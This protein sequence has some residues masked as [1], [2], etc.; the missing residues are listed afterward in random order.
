[1]PR[2]GVP[3]RAAAAAIEQGEPR[4]RM[5]MQQPDNQKNLLLAILMSVGVLLLWQ[6]LYAGPKLKEEQERQ[7]RI[8][9]EQQAKAPVP[10]APGTVPGVGQP[11][12]PAGSTPAAAPPVAAVGAMTREQALKASPRIQIDTP[13]IAGSISLKGA[14]IDDVRLK[15]HREDARPGSPLVA[16][17]SPSEASD[18]YFAEHGWAGATGS[19]A[20]LPT[21]DTLWRAETS[22]ALAPDKPVVLGWDNG[23]GLSFRRTIS[24]DRDY[25]FR[26]TDE[27][28]N[29]GQSDLAVHPYARLFRY[30]IPKIEGFFI[31]HEGLIGFIGDAR[32]QELTYSDVQKDGGSRNYKDK[33]GGW[34]GFTDKYWATALVPPQDQP[35]TANLALAQKK[36]AATDKEA[37]QADYI[38][39]AVALPRGS[40]TKI[41]NRLFAG[42]KQVGIVN[43]YEAN[44]KI[45]EFNYVID[46]GWF[47]FITK[48]LYY[49]ITWFNQLLGNFGLAILAVTVLVK[50]A[51]FPLA[52]KSYES[53]AKMKKLQPEMER[54]KERY[55]D[56]KPA[57]QKE[58]MTLYQKE[59]INP[60]AGCLPILLQIPVFFALYKVLFVSIDMRH[61]PFFGWIKDLSAADPTSIFNLFGLLPYAVPEFLQVGV[62]P[63][64][65]GATMWLQMQLNPKQ[66]D[67]IQ[68]Q[69]FNWMPVIFTFLLA[70]FPAGLV[71]YWAWNNVLSLMQQYVIMKRQKVDV[72]L[73]DN[74]KAAIAGLGRMFGKPKA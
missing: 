10:G 21:P 8:Q 28:S 33:K 34:L 49:L 70:T 13:S 74:L 66:P 53:M 18:S 15:R 19:Q 29:Q 16:V 6:V 45:L 9:A 22:H 42:A 14:R 58:L 37:F 40:T 43:A 4:Q 65:M 50:V 69:I 46:W 17:L 31:Q 55:K 67:P 64:I 54:L 51:F 56:D 1:M 2:R 48:P 23:D 73:V 61:A 62:W 5:Q 35:Y 7:R 27:V 60:A 20:R 32:L 25:M 52:N 38:M 24:V 72:P 11:P 26:I 39:G 71:I 30:G 44:E 36:K 59:K 3:L 12:L 47:F 57:M 41:E 68:Q 63:L